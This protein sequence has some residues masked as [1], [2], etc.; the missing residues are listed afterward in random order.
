ME[1]LTPPE[2]TS[3]A[4][5]SPLN[6]PAGDPVDAT[7]P[8]KNHSRMLFI[9]RIILW[10]I[11]VYYGVLSWLA[12]NRVF[13]GAIILIPIIVILIYVL[14]KQNSFSPR[15]FWIPALQ[16]FLIIFGFVIVLG[17]NG[18]PGDQATPYAYLNKRVVWGDMALV[19]LSTYLTLFFLSS[20]SGPKY[21]NIKWAA[22]VVPL[23]LRLL[24]FFGGRPTI[25]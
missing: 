24:R 6:V 8:K 21:R 16:I 9:L 10:G 7:V 20:K 1:N 15:V 12:K 5:E 17:L 19:F 4:S 23:L 14:S 3:S 18:F 2:V 22:C 25:F 13:L 11:F